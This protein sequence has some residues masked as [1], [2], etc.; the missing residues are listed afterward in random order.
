MWVFSA[1]LLFKAYHNVYTSSTFTEKDHKIMLGKKWSDKADS[2]H[3]V[4][5]NSGVS[6]LRCGYEIIVQTWTIGR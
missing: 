5:S 6:S 4:K 1:F 2:E 3:V